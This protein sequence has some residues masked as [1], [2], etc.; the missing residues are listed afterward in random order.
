[1]TAPSI[2]R[3]NA[4]TVDVHHHM[5]PPHYRNAL[6]MSGI[7]TGGIPAWSPDHSSRMME[8]L[9]VDR[10][11][12]SISSPGVWF[13][14]DVQ[15]RE[16]ARSCNEY[17]ASLRAKHPDRFGALAILPLP[18]LEGALEETRYALDHLGL[19]G[20][21]L[22]SNVDGNYIGDP[23]SDDLMAELNRRNAFVL[24]HPNHVPVGNEDVALHPWA[25]YPIDVARAYARLV[26]NEVLICYP[27]IRWVLAHAGGV[28]PYLAER[29]G[30]AHYAKEGKPRWGR[31]ILDMAAKRNRG[32][33]LAQCMG[34]D[35]VGAANPVSFAA[36]DRLVSWERIHFGSNFPWDSEATTAAAISFLGRELGSPLYLGAPEDAQRSSI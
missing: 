23:E 13:G 34:Y 12:L 22:L 35:T 16:L 17:S 32:L 36:L 21:I 20:V 3:A 5:V 10:A 9:K 31:I 1:M 4:I 28:V 7:D 25:E 29:L 18:D 6:E 14:D 8:R 27:D 15:A 26:Y 2:G 24:L 30:K 11:L 19:D 33:E